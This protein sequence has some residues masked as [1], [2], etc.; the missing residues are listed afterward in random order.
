MNSVFKPLEELNK[1]TKEVASD[2]YDVPLTYNGSIEEI[3]N[4]ID[5]FNFKTQELSSVEI[6]RNDFIASV[7]HEFK[8]HLSSINGYVT[9]LQD[10]DLTTEE[11]EEYS[12]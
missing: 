9:L 4:T 6:M 5:N 10:P 8:T 7:S 1:A 2:N 11:R 12:A 3:R